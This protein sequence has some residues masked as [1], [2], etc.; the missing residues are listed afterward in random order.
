MWVVIITW[1]N[2]WNGPAGRMK[3]SAVMKREWKRQNQR[4]TSMHLTNYG[5]HGRNLLTDGGQVI[6]GEC[7]TCIPE[8]HAGQH[9]YP[10][11][12]IAPVVDVPG[13]VDVTDTFERDVTDL[14]HD[15]NEIVKNKT[16][17]EQKAAAVF[18]C[19]PEICFRI[20][21]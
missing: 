21:Q 16:S 1:Q 18:S 2:Y 7:R 5:L 15:I 20:H 11:Q 12:E 8:N 13:I 6:L 10:E 9:H 4:E 14:D 19:L 17:D 3:P